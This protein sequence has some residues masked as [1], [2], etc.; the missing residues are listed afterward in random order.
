MIAATWR[1]P[2]IQR[3]ARSMSYRPVAAHKAFRAHT[4][5]SGTVVAGRKDKPIQED[6][7]LVR[8]A[9]WFDPVANPWYGQNIAGMRGIRFDLASEA[10]NEHSQVVGLLGRFR[11]PY[12]YEKLALCDD[13]F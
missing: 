12:C 3:M 5:D 8:S 2:G 9:A 6:A 13:L 4:E 7:L 10:A 11:S 1:L